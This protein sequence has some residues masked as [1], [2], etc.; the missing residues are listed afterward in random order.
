MLRAVNT[1][2]RLGIEVSGDAEDL[3]MLYQAL[4]ELAGDED[5]WPQLEEARIRIL[6]VCYDLRHALQGHRDV[7]AYDNGL[8]PEMMR[9]WGRLGPRENVRFA[10]KILYPEALFVTA[11]LN[12]FLFI[13]TGP[14]GES[15][16]SREHADQ[17]DLNIVY[18]RYFQTLVL[19]CAEEITSKSGF[20]R[21]RKAL[22]TKFPWTYQYFSQYL[23]YLDEEFVR[24]RPERRGVILPTLVE[25]MT[26]KGP[27]YQEMVNAIR[28]FAD[29]HGCEPESVRFRDE[30]D[31]EHLE[32]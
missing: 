22:N 15:I 5:E 25:R 16:T 3:Q 30:I 10:F 4:S 31:W 19:R 11:A 23:D 8:T 9:A 20:K 2:H 18:G 13:Y 27:E 14:H 6:A 1:P 24:K 12:D 28:A 29:E 7:E 32:W 26:S 17:M 21:L